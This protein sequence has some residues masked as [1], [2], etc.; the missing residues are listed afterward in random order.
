MASKKGL[1]VVEN[2]RKDS[3]K[4][5]ALAKQVMLAEKMEPL[6]LR[7]A[8]EHYIEHWV[9]YTHAGLF[10]M[11]C[12]ATGGN[13][14]D[15][16]DAQAAIALMTAA[17]DIH[18]DII[19]KTNTKSK[20]P[21][22][23]GKYGEELTLLL[24]NAFLIGGI[25]LF[26]D[27]TT[28]FP[29][30]KALKTLETTK[31][32]LFEVGNAHSL[33]ICLK[34]KKTVKQEEYLKII[35][36]KAAAMEI[37]IVLGA[38]YGGAKED[39]IEVFARLGRIMGILTLLRDE[40]IDVF[41]INELR[42]RIQV[43]DLPLPLQLAMHNPK[44]KTEINKV[45]K[46]KMTKSTVSRIVDLTLESKPAKEMK[47]RMQLLIGEGQALLNKLPSKKPLDKLQAFV[48]FMLEDL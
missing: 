17:F 30:E 15:N 48:S 20:V 44:T 45:L 16:L 39:E 19:D 3:E 40:L 46:I 21:T 5:F 37:D 47:G 27:S 4:G 18:D 7:G 33:E 31:K 28:K 36:M 42:Q 2:L 23:Y 32:L 9:N 11:A 35:E 38:I 22:V 13:I 34:K 43:D 29:K 26:A 24:G 6:E 25:K 12:E 8:L 14:E 41:D 1:E 10:A